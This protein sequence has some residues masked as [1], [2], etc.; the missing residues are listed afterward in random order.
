MRQQLAVLNRKT[1]RP[2]LHPS[3]RW[4]WVLISSIWPDWRGALAIAKPATVIG[5]HRKGFRLCWTWKSRSRRSGRPPV[6]R[7]VRDLIRR[8][9]GENPLWGAP[10]I[11]GE[12]L[13]LGFEV[14]E[15]TV[16]RYILRH[17]K[18]P[19]QT[20]RSFLENHVGCLASMD[21]FV[22]PTA[23]FRLL[24]G[25]IIL[26]HDRRRIVHFGVT[27]HPT[28]IWIAQQI[29]EAFPWGT[30]PLYMIR[31]RGGVYGK[32]ARYR[33]AEPDQ[34]HHR[35]RCSEHSRTGLG[36]CRRCPEWNERRY[37]GLFQRRN[38]GAIEQRF[39]VKSPRP[40]RYSR[41]S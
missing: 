27:E 12:L 20:W 32:A 36:N 2:R 39:R 41:S 10:R 19:S 40:M 30:A 8:M 3:D 31:D 25:F 11:H 37:G 7:E 14:S 18:P 26:R 21:L 4:F 15:R 13:K 33:C 38:R 23:A 17:P 1:P 35:R 24:Y 9:C 34:L 5:W 29:T 6:S 28:A 22:V 16:S